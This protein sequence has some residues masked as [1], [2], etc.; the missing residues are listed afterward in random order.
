MVSGVSN[1]TFPGE[2]PITPQ[3]GFS[4]LV[5][6]KPSAGERT[7]FKIARALEELMLSES[8]ASISVIA[9][10]EVAGISRQT[11][12]NHFIDK[13]DLVGWISD[14]LDFCTTSRIGIDMT[15]EEAVRAKL[16]FMKSKEP[17]YCEI[18]KAEAADQLIERAVDTVFRYYEQNLSRIAGI[19]L[20]EEARLELRQFCYGS[21]G[22]VSEWAR[23]GM[24][25]PVELV[26]RAERTALPPFAKAVFL[27]AHS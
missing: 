4:L 20:S 19:V 18:Y 9:I 12:Y 11:F 22:I 10:S 21:T 15:W 24:A 1:P 26:L 13:S 17:F 27:G 16:S 8:F 6:E 14:Q 2:Y 7:K 25:T 3:L 23:T 5:R